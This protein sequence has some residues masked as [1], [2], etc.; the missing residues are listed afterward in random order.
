MFAQP[1]RPP[2]RDFRSPNPSYNACTQVLFC[3][4]IRSAFP[5]RM[6]LSSLDGVAAIEGDR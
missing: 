5:Q 3:G 4:V 2:R 1:A 6:T